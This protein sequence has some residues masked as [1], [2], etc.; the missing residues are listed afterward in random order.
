MQ[1]H[2]HLIC[3]LTNTFA[4]LLHP[5][6]IFDK[7]PLGVYAPHTGKAGWQRLT[8]KFFHVYSRCSIG[9][10]ELG[11]TSI[12]SFMLLW[13]LGMRQ[14]TCGRNWHN[15][16]SPMFVLARQNDA[17]MHPQLMWNKPRI[18]GT[19]PKVART[20]VATSH[21]RRMLGKECTQT[22]NSSKWQALEVSW[23]PNNSNTSRSGHKPPR[24]I[25]SEGNKCYPLLQS[26]NEDSCLKAGL[27]Q[28]TCHKHQWTW[29]ENGSPTTID[30]GPTEQTIMRI[31]HNEQCAWDGERVENGRYIGYQGVGKRAMILKGIVCSNKQCN[32]FSTDTHLCLFTKALWPYRDYY[33]ITF[34]SLLLV[35]TPASHW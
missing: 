28:M 32:I 4:K 14:K 30:E 26:S 7:E 23:T 5:W 20:R 3:K 18:P 17:C 6:N 22:L 27:K 10:S 13:L 1:L 15:T 21:H 16:R 29:I 2:P 12:C 24:H 25:R 35:T 8:H 11:R 34:P 19:G 31:V 9:M 33:L